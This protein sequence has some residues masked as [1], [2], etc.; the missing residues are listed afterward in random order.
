MKNL[1]FFV[2]FFC[3]TSHAQYSLD[4]IANMKAWASTYKN[5]DIYGKTA[6]GDI[7]NVSIVN[8]YLEDGTPDSMEIVRVN[9]TNHT[10]LHKK[11]NQ[12]SSV[13]AVWISGMDSLGQVYMSLI[14]GVR[15][16]WKF[17]LGNDYINVDMFKAVKTIETLT[18]EVEELKSEIA[19]LKGL[20]YEKK[21]PVKLIYTGKVK[22]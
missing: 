18:S 17:K 20:I 14:V 19:E 2:L 5:A 13:S 10:T 1:L 8:H 3:F 6:S 11:I 15:C 16:V 7:Y 4:T 12:P 9:L 22:K 21:S